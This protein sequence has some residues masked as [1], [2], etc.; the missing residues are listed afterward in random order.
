V[1]G[2]GVLP[3]YE[4]D[5]RDAHAWPELYF[6]GLGWVPFEP[7]PSRGVVPAY[8]T[9]TSTPGAGAIENNDG[10]VPSNGPSP[11][12]APSTT[13][14]PLPGAGGG[15]EAG[16]QLLPW[17]LGTAGVLGLMLV[18]ASPRLVRLG[19][20]ARRLRRQDP[21]LDDAV[22]RAWSEFLDLGTDYG[23]PPRP[24]ET[25][26]VYS[27]RLRGSSLLGEAGGMDDA[28]HQ[29]VI[30]LTTDFERRRYGPPA[31]QDTP[32]GDERAADRAPLRI[33]AVQRSLRA[34][35][36]L[37][38]RLRADWLPPS[39]IRRLGR[40]LT[41]PFRALAGL[42]RRTAQAAARSWSRAREGL[43][44]LSEG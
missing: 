5:A 28:G 17:L 42:A 7:T 34:N 6:Q 16:S 38:R 4:V 9:E 29:A 33:A 20:R 14:V 35:V 2:Q 8:A 36:P 31:R 22:P 24:S 1:A 40:M 13:P 41:A 26:R 12:P 23:L 37:S 10:L 30:S 3:E 25:P 27:A 11:T 21:A 19:L 39:V 15:S 43:R 18:A 44:H 32:S